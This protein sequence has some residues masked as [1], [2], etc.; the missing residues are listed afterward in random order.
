MICEIIRQISIHF[1]FFVSCP[2]PSMRALET[3]N[4]REIAAGGQID[5]FVFHGNNEMCAC[6]TNCILIWNTMRTIDNEFPYCT[7]NGNANRHRFGCI[8]F[9]QLTQTITCHLHT[10]NVWYVLSYAMRNSFP[11]GSHG[12]HGIG[13]L[14]SWIENPITINSI[15]W[16]IH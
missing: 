5:N 10:S 16:K 4:T 2:S 8:W 6:D 7:D 15:K 11:L 14:S 1:D 9:G 3:Y 12:S 13:H